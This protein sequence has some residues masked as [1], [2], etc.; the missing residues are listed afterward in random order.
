M[1]SMVHY[2]INKCSPPTPILSHID[3]VHAL[4]SHFLQICLDTNIISCS[5]C[6][7]IRNLHIV[8]RFLRY[9][10]QILNIIAFIIFLNRH[11]HEHHHLANMVWGHLLIRSD[12]THLEISLMV[13]PGFFCLLVCSIL[14]FPVIYFGESCLYVAT[15][16][17]CMPVFCQKQGLY[18]VILQ[19]PAV[20]LIHFISAA[21]ILPEYLAFMTQ[22]SVP[23]LRAGRD[24]VLCS[25]ILILFTVFCG[26]RL[27]FSNGYSVCYQ[28]PLR[29]HRI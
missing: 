10:Q 19:S 21:V 7:Y 12:F 13:T 11:Y 29:F 25:F 4:T 16:V 23:Y 14:A 24:S 1:D 28:C 8:F 17:Y 27:L 9:N 26:L 3:P 18:L 15:N 2:R 22:F 6:R 5:A 20:L